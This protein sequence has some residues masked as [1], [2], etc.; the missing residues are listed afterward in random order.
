MKVRI[1]FGLGTQTLANDGGS[2]G[3]LV[4]ALE[5]LRF[6]SLWLS[7][8]LTGDAPDPL[9][10]LAF[11]AGR[12][13]KLKLG[14]SVL[15]LPGRNPVVLAKEMASLD[16]L[17]GGRF[18]PAVGLGAPVPAEHRAFGVG[19]KERAPWFDEALALMR[20]LWTEDDVTHH[21]E[22]FQVEGITLRPKP[23]QEP[24]E[25]WLGGQA[26]SELRRVGRVGDGWLPSF[27]TVAD[28][29]QGWELVTA[30]AAEHQRTIDPEH[31][32]ALV[33]YSRHGVPDA[34]RAFLAQRRP[35]LDPADVVPVGLDGLRGRLEAFTTVGASK[36][37]VL[38]LDEPADWAQELA[39]VHDAVGDLQT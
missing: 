24:L 5:D 39:A 10:A 35:D 17:S 1:G 37:V 13:R 4:D 34:L 14:T 2:F 31:L 3:A 22:R 25:V 15:V 7:E 16:R 20:R 21:G 38:P 19:R 23:V 32:G 36:F 30:T 33:A 6:D 29:A 18:L 26:P 11:A 9:T 8:R 27:C 28:V 12:T